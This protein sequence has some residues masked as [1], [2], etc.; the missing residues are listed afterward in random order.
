MHSEEYQG[1][2][3]LGWQI[4]VYRLT[5]GGKGPA[6]LS[7]PAGTRLA[8]WETSVG[9]LDWL[10][11]LVTEGKAL[12][13]GGD[14][15]PCRYTAQAEFLLPRILGQPPQA[16]NSAHMKTV[17]HESLIKECRFDEWLLVEAWDQ[18]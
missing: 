12:D 18:S 1:H 7:S 16:R 15:Y 17:V 3:M 9:G 4:G 11:E 10:D 8:A 14:G 6:K 5:D 13:I 2:I